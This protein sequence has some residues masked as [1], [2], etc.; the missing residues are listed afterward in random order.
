M[1]PSGHPNLRQFGWKGTYQSPPDHLINDFYRPAFARATVYDRA[2]GYYSSAVMGLITHSL[3]GFITRGGT[4]RLIASPANLDDRD[5][6]AFGKGE[7]QL[8][9]RLRQAY[10]AQ[11]ELEALQPLAPALRDR[12]RLLTWMIANGQME[13]KIALR[14]YPTAYRLFHEKFG[15]FA[16]LE[17]HRLSFAGSNNETVSGATGNAES[18]NVDLEW[19]G[20]RDALRC[21]NWADRFDA[22]WNDDLAGIRT[23]T[24]TE[25]LCDPLRQHFGEQEP[26]PNMTIEKPDPILT[27]PDGAG[28]NAG[29][30]SGGYTLP[31]PRPLLPELPEEKELRDYQKAAV[32]D[33]LKNGCHGIF[34]MA[35]GVGKTVTALAAATVASKI[36]AD[37]GQPLL[38][39]VIVPLIDLAEQ[40]R[41]AA[42]E[43]GFR[44]AIWSGDASQAERDRVHRS[45]HLA[46]T[47]TLPRVEMVITTADS[48]TPT[49]GK[50]PST[51]ALQSSLAHY[52]GHLLVI[53]D[54]VHSLGTA[55]RL[56]A[57]PRTE[58]SRE[59][60]FTLGLSATPKRHMD[61]TGT[62]ALIEYFGEPLA[63][64]DIK[65][66]IRLG[67]L[68]KYQ[69]HPRFV[70]LTHD[71]ATEYRKL[72]AKI[73]K[74][75][76][77]GN[78]EARDQ[79]IRARVRLTQHAANKMAALR[80]ILDEI[81]DRRW[82]LVYT[83]EG[84]S[85][86]PT[87][88]S[89]DDRTDEMRTIN[90]VV[91]VLRD[92]Y[93][94]KAEAYTGST[95]KDERIKLQEA[96]A[97]T[98]IDALVAMKCL[99]EGVDIPE[100]RTGIIM[101]STQNPRQFVQR[102][103]RLLRLHPTSGKVRATVY[104]MIVRPP[105]GMQP[106][107]A[108][109]TLIGNELSRAYE[110]AEAAENHT[111]RFE[112]RQAAIDAGLD[113]SLFPWMTDDD[114]MQEWP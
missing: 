39:L 111:A 80:S 4:I 66:A 87:S 55:N 32:N 53:G 41:E 25:W 56:A 77:A 65:E 71:E 102:R 14:E 101:A 18:F 23:W 86:S 90:Q 45:F 35:T 59:Q 42:E 15:L 112:I 34:A 54:E 100:V 95:P 94:V 36:T 1:T 99:D 62:D 30:L 46:R 44:P 17:G 61:D 58:G 31:A 6:N 73:A 70:D 84:W 3:D 72:S 69:Y 68:V 49:G 28:D 103:G 51:H 91:K 107:P 26:N 110:L 29:D 40:W 106:S 105:Q 22:I 76:A 113:S 48:L 81:E 20:G 50:D 96:I 114:P 60:L 57:L 27:E 8:A 13:V 5:L 79:A 47:S 89:D 75:I 21:A 7:Q 19:E 97:E 104:D 93:D 83:A 24:A 63:M 67:A 16:D 88:S 43:F 85:P 33:W 78:D 10:E 74:A 98:K 92:E 11:I 108:E 64:I 52:H 2:V 12:V 9:E 38:V 37:R 109:M 82:M